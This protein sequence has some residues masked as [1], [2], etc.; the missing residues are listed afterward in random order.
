MHNPQHKKII[1]F[2]GVCNLCNAAVDFIIRRDK[3]GEFMFASLQGEKG[4]EILRSFHLQEDYLDNFILYQNGKLYHR[5]TAFLKVMT[6]LGGL[7]K[8]LSIFF[9]IPRFIRDWVYDLVA[10]NRYRWF[11][12]RETCRV[13]SAAERERFLD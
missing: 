5:S 3:E 12:R 7:W 13:A 2:D 10:R 1:L 8:L 4:K 9:L 11:G 6:G